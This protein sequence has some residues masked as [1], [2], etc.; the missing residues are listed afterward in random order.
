MC[1]HLLLVVTTFCRFFACGQTVRRCRR[2]PRNL[3][4]DGLSPDYH[5]TVQMTSR[6]FAVSRYQHSMTIT[7][8]RLVCRVRRKNAGCCS[9]FFLLL[10][11]PTAVAGMGFLPPFVCVSVCL[12]L[13][14]IS[15]KPMQLGPP[16]LTRKCS[17]MSPEDP[18]ILWSGG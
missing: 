4:S 1:L 13:R 14:T 3:F 18:F 7:V 6:V 2:R 8:T 5:E 17:T 16:N 12:F 11:T 15:R 10:P 9:C